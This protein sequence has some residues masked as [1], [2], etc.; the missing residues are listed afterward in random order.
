MV[1]KS[2]C[3]VY[4]GLG[5]VAGLVAGAVGAAILGIPRIGKLK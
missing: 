1:K 2:T 4:C 5:L 3:Y